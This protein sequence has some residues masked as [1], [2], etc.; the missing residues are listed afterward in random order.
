MGRRGAITDTEESLLTLLNS[1][2][3]VT[4]RVTTHLQ[5]LCPQA[6]VVA[7]LYHEQM[8]AL[9]DI[10]YNPDRW[11]DEYFAEVDLAESW[12][13]PLIILHM[14]T[15]TL[16]S[17]IDF[18]K[19]ITIRAC[20][21]QNIYFISGLTQGLSSWYEQYC[22]LFNQQGITVIDAPCY[23]ALVI[24]QLDLGIDRVERSNSGQIADYFCYQGGLYSNPER[25][26]IVAALL[27]YQSLGTIEFAGGFVS[28]DQEF[29]AY[30]EN[31]TNYADRPWVEQLLVSKNLW[32]NVP[33]ETSINDKNARVSEYQ[34]GQGS[35]CQV[36]RETINDLPY[37][38]VTE[39]T[40]K[41]FL[42]CRLPLPLCYN[43]VKNLE[44]LGF[45]FMHDLIDYSYQSNTS[46]SQRVKSVGQIIF[47]LSQR[48]SIESLAKILTSS[49]VIEH[50]FDW[51]KSK[52][53]FRRVETEIQQ[54]MGK[55]LAFDK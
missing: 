6:K 19:W 27:P 46:F 20:N 54:K 44:Q 16:D 21:L 2:P 48:Y 5:C 24:P 53:I 51:V 25:E 9:N 13:R 10:D 14:E 49:Q 32:N 47:E 40:L 39:K 8:T 55:S 35:V 33:Q 38:C 7:V 34:Y 4:A 43:G 28:S 18:H 3:E 22:R 31:V 15:F 50:N 42:N 36:L 41:C 45:I 29:D 1:F 30:L 12:Q 17:F 11:W 26:F 23:P 37:S 52:K